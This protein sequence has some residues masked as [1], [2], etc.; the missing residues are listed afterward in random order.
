MLRVALVDLGM[1]NLHSVERAIARAG[2]DA[3]LACTVDR[4]GDP[5]ALR[6]ADKI[7][8]PGQGAF[9]D[10]AAALARGMG[11]ALREQIA[12]G[13]PYFGICLGLQALFA[14]S[15]EAPGAAGLGVFAGK[16]AR[17]SPSEGVKIPHMGWNRVTL[18][19]PKAGALGAFDGEEPYFYFVHSYHAVPDDPA[20]VAA[21]TDHGPHRVTAAV[22]RD[23]VTATQF[24]PEKSQE[25]GLRL[26]AAFLSQ[27]G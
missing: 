22:Q 21:V 19:R 10:C 3:G 11:D 17:L 16:V 6:R 14:E 1:G 26:L 23:N 12:A 20:L 27:N 4:T 8:V 9:R 2:S 13:K 5:E 18:I 25:A 15:E 7:V 24:H